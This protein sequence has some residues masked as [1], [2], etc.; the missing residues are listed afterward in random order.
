MRWVRAASTRMNRRAHRLVGAEDGAASERWQQ[1]VGDLSGSSSDGDGDWRLREGCRVT[2][3]VSTAVFRAVCALTLAHVRGC[4]SAR[5]HRRDRHA[6]RKSR[7]LMN[8]NPS[9]G[10]RRAKSL[11]PYVAIDAPPAALGS[12]CQRRQAVSS[13][14]GRWQAGSFVGATAR[15]VAFIHACA[16]G[17]ECT[18]CTDRP[19]I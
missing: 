1:R 10:R 11:V 17:P 4:Q 9:I 3:R 7:G 5:L 6:E 18:N 14:V 12:R 2:Q 16:T 8:P 19:H 13:M 15:L